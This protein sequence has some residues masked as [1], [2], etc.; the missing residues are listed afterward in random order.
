M[1]AAEED[2]STERWAVVDSV[3][4][5]GKFRPV[6]ARRSLHKRHSNPNEPYTLNPKP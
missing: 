5:Q 3:G 1:A 6:R 4:K 2:W